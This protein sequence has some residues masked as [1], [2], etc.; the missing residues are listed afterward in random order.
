M[1]FPP[2][3]DPPC[4]TMRAVKRRRLGGPLRGL[5]KMPDNS[6]SRHW[7]DLAE[8]ARAR[9]MKAPQAE[10]RML[11]LADF[12]EHVAERIEQLYMEATSGASQDSK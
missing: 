9:A 12:Y 5:R 6:D 1:A 3:S 2:I 11:R 4:M 10:R 7:H 8:K